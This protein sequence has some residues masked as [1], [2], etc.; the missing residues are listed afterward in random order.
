M[1]L[2]FLIAS[3]T[4]GEPSA[5]LGFAEGI[6]S[7]MVCK[8]EAPQIALPSRDDIRQVLLDKT[9]G[10]LS[11]RQLLRLRRTAVIERRDS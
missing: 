4:P 1:R 3:L 9:F 6:A 10:S 5:P 11:E 7:M 8:I 2:Y